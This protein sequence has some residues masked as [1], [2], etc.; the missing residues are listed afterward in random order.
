M[1]HFLPL[2]HRLKS[3]AVQVLE[4]ETP[5]LQVFG[6]SAPVAAGQADRK[7]GGGE[8]EWYFEPPPRDPR[9]DRDKARG[10]GKRGGSEGGSGSGGGNGSF[11][12]VGRFGK[13]MDGSV[14]V[15]E[16]GR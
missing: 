12:V 5:G 11:T 9:L 15:T 2:T 16:V 1:V 3:G 7:A 4:P 14:S 8:A 13:R 6:T 10:K